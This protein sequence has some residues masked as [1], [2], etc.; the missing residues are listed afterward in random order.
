MPKKKKKKKKK[1]K[2]ILTTGPKKDEYMMLR[3]SAGEKRAFQ[4]AARTQGLSLSHW[5]RLACWQSIK[6]HRGKVDLVEL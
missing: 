1:K 4:A 6:K 3:M 2:T 5:L